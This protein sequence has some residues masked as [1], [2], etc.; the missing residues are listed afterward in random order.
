MIYTYIRGSALSRYVCKKNN[1]RHRVRDHT[2]N[3]EPPD[4]CTPIYME[5]GVPRDSVDRFS[6]LY[7]CKLFVFVLLLAIMVVRG[8]VRCS[9]GLVKTAGTFSLSSLL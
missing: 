4:T 2:M 3:E 7:Y 6:W 1:N 5:G 8:N 9:F